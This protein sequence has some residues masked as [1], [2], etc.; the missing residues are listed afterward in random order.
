MTVLT[1][2]GVTIDSSDSD[3]D[4][5]EEKQPSVSISRSYDMCDINVPAIHAVPAQEV[6]YSTDQE[7]PD[8]M[9]PVSL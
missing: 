6:T 1:E 3:E 2:H 8:E 9:Y 5:D 4:V 7:Q